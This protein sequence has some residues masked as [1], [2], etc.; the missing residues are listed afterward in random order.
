MGTAALTVL[1][2]GAAPVRAADLP[3]ELTTVARV[4]FQGRHAVKE[5]ELRAAIKTRTS[6]QVVFRDSP[7]LR[8]DFLRADTVAIE[9]VYQQHGYLD[10]RAT[11]RLSPATDPVQTIV[12]FVIEE[13]R[14]TRIGRVDLSGVTV[15]PTDPLRRKLFAR[16]GKPFNPYFLPADTLKIAEA[17]H[18]RG[19]F[20]MVAASTQRESTSITV[21][22]SVNEGARFRFGEVRIAN[23]EH[24]SVS[25]GFVRR[26][27]LQRPGSVYRSTLV[28]KSIERLY[29]TGVFSQVQLT[30]LIDSTA[31]TIEFDLALRERKPRWVD[32]GIGSGTN[33]RL[34][35]T[36]EWGHRSLF[37]RGM[38]G[39]LAGALALDS[40]ARFLLS[41][42]EASLLEPWMF[43][44]RTRGRLTVYHEIR[45]ER[46]GLDQRLIENQAEGVSFQVLRRFGRYA[47]LSLLQDFTFVRQ[48]QTFNDP[49]L[50]DS[51]RAV[52]N[53]E[54]TPSFT[55]NRLQLGADRDTRDFPIHVTHGSFQSASAEIAGGPLRGTSSFTKQQFSSSWY[56]PLSPVLQIATRLGGG[57]I[58]P[59]GDPVQFSQEPN[60]DP[61][62]A[63]VPV[64]DRF[65][66]GGVN[67]LRGYD[68]SELPINGGLV[69]MRGNLELRAQVYGPFG[70]EVFVDAGNVWARHDGV[71]HGQFT[72]EVSSR[73]MTPDDVR[74]VFGFGPQVLLPFGPLRIDYTWWARPDENGKRQR[75]IYQ[76][77]I[78][79][80]F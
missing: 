1:A 24:L 36:G 23:L 31:T 37:E 47:R 12:T 41:R 60:V 63:R 52:L 17:Y 56:T 22:Y 8:L 55:T 32:A 45:H 74:W 11:Y 35:A 3:S 6:S 7:L 49:A 39:T 28:Q 20:P 14:R 29:E 5:K 58:T 68:E 66:I 4:K 78:G 48:N 2:A 57:W 61:E 53:Q 67:S 59:F 50:S 33:E 10:T 77:A 30:P 46:D 27:L 62:V 44:T 54:I 40:Q 75:G 79:S 65:R 13:G 38:Q 16:P 34:L 73:R 72:P 15:M 9:N 80:S 70:F 43:A 18:D 21:G 19:Y 51:E 76:F 26:E 42:S 64:L 71:R 69:L 25:E